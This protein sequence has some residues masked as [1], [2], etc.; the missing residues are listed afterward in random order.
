L[1]ALRAQLIRGAFDLQ[2]VTGEGGEMQKRSSA[3]LRIALAL[4]LAFESYRLATYTVTAD[5]WDLRSS[6][7][8]AAVWFLPAIGIGAACVLVLL[9]RGPRWAWLAVA[10]SGLW[11]AL[12]EAYITYALGISW[13]PSVDLVMG[14]YAAFLAL[15][16]LLDPRLLSGRTSPRDGSGRAPVTP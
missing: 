6:L 10:V 1:G 11:L 15:A 3:V 8:S 13:R 12:V 9:A 7:I 4:P 14:L 5:R 2:A 16:F